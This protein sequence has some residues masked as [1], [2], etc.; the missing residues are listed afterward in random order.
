MKNYIHLSIVIAS[1]LLTGCTTIAIDSPQPAALSLGRGS[2]VSIVP[3]SG[4]DAGELAMSLAQRFSAEGFY[5]MVDRW[6]LG[7]TMNERNFQRMSFVEGG[8]PRS[9]IRGADAFIYIGAG[10]L[11][12]TSNDS[13]SF[14]YNGNTT[15]SYTTKTTVNYSAG[16]RVVQTGSSR[17]AGVRRVDL[18]DTKTAYGTDGYPDAPDAIPIV[19]SLREKAAT[20]MFNTLHPRVVK[21]HR[22]VAGTKSASAKAA[23]R[24]ANSGL[25][26]Q[27][28]ES[29]RAGVREMPD[30]LGARHIL[31]VVYQGAGRY[32][33]ASRTLA[34]LVGMP[35]G[36]KFAKDLQFNSSLAS[37]AARYN[38]QMQ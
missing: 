30:D 9:R 24:Y 15:T 31:A 5:D 1:A 34:E 16:Y 3:E 28:V 22:T 38:A 6:N 35:G 21:E 7:Q 8:A 13:S 26:S 12:R 2:Q 37:N 25:W 4:N 18:E 20:E 32:G 10:S 33:D 23:V 11:A 17:L 36:S 14:T 27:A 29:A 19:Q